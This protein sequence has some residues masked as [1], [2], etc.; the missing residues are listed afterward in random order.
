MGLTSIMKVIQFT[1]ENIPVKDDLRT[2]SE[3]FIEEFKKE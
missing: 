3:N 1:I 2:I